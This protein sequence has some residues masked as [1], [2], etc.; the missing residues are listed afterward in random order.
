[1]L[2]PNSLVV[3]LRIVQSIFEELYEVHYP[4]GIADVELKERIGVLRQHFDGVYQDP[5]PVDY[6]DVLTRFAY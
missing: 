2:R 6:S 5:H 4:N 1:M 3:S